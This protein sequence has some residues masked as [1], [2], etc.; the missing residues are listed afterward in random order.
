MAKKM[1]RFL[2]FSYGKV[3]D[4]PLFHDGGDQPE[5]L[6][7]EETAWLGEV[8]DITRPY[9]LARGEELGAF[10]SDDERKAIEDGS[11]RGPDAPALVQARRAAAEAV[12]QPLADES[13]APADISDMSSEQVAD[14]IKEQK[15]TVPQ[16]VDLAD[17]NN[18]DS[19]N[20]VLDAEGIASESDPRAGVTKAL[21]ARLAAAAES[22]PEFDE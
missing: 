8:H 17:P 11:Y 14:L 1:I 21:E 2:Q 10:F 3:I 7:K 5:T 16:T 22:H 12:V 18:V 6:L 4:N 15:L 19:I 13:G 20:K 9:D